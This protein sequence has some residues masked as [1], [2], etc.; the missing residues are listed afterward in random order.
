[1]KDPTKVM[2]TITNK[3]NDGSSL[4][5]NSFYNLFFISAND[6]EIYVYDTRDPMRAYRDISSKHPEF[7]FLRI[8]PY[9]TEKAAREVCSIFR[10]AKDGRQRLIPTAE[11][12][13]INIQTIDCLKL[14]SSESKAA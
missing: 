11:V 14:P 10:F 2:E 3:M 4:F 6:G 1:M 13:K 9:S 5:S 12:V 8:E 7:E